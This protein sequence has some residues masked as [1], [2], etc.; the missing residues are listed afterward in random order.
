PLDGLTCAAEALDHTVVAAPGL[1]VGG[2]V[3]AVDR[4]HRMLLETPDAVVAHDGD[5]RKVVA[6]ERVVVHAVEADRAVALQQHDLPVWM[7]DTSR[8]RVAQPGAEAAVGPRVHPATGLEGV[9]Q[10]A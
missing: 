2:D 10:L 6:D 3:V 5:D 4:L 7:R 8:D 9:D 1:E